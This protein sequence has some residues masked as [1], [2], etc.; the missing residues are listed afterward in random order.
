[1]AGESFGNQDVLPVMSKV[2]YTFEGKNVWGSYSFFRYRH[3]CVKLCIK[4]RMHSLS[5]HVR[6]MACFPLQTCRRKWSTNWWSSF[7]ALIQVASRVL[8]SC[9]ICPCHWSK[10]FRRISLFSIYI[11][12]IYIYRYIFFIMKK[13]TK[14]TEPFSMALRYD[15]LLCFW[16]HSNASGSK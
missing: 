15:P 7:S 8:N 13:G 2:S 14:T 16:H 4:T 10:L 12:D 5:T 11:Y 3:R 9:L 6:T 1:M